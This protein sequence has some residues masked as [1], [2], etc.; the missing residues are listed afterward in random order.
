MDRQFIIDSGLRQGKDINTINKALKLEGFKPY[1]PNEILREQIIDSG[2]RQGKRPDI[3]NKALQYEGIKPDYNPLLEKWGDVPGNAVRDAKDIGR[4]LTSFGGELLTTGRDYVEDIFNQP[5]GKRSSKIAESFSN[6]I[7]SSALQKALL[8][9]G[10]GA[11]AGRRLGSLGMIPGAILGGIVST[12]GPKETA[13]ALL[14][15]YNTKIEDFNPTNWNV[16]PLAMIQGA[17]YKP[18]EASLD[19]LSLGGAKAA[20][21]AIKGRV[22]KTAIANQLLPD[23][24]T[25]QFNRYITN[26]INTSR[27]TQSKRYDA[28]NALLA[29]PLADREKIAN[30]LI[31]NDIAGL[32]EKELNIG[33]TIK[34][35]LKELENDIV[36]RGFMESDTVR[37]NVVSQYIM[38]KLGNKT[39][40]LLQKDVSDIINGR[41][42][43]PEIIGEVD[44]LTDKIKDLAKEGNKLYNEGKI[45]YVSQALKTSTDPRGLVKASEIVDPMGGYFD[46]Q[47]IIGRTTTKELAPWLDDTLNYQLNTLNKATEVEDVIRT[48]TNIDGMVADLPVGFT[49]IRK[50]GKDKTLISLGTLKQA[51]NNALKEGKLFDV[52]S[53]INTATKLT[54]DSKVIDK[55]KLEAIVNALTPVK[56]TEGRYL[57][58][59]FKKAALATPHWVAQ[60]RVGNVSNNLLSG[61]TPID[62]LDTSKYREYTPIELKQT[63]SFGNFVD[64]GPEGFKRSLGFRDVSKKGITKAI[65]SYKQLMG[66]EKNYNN[67]AKALAGI[68]SGVSEIASNPVFKFEADLE[69]T[70]RF[71]NY[72]RQAKR[73]AKEHNMKVEAVLEKAKTDK[74]LKYEFINQGNKD[75]GDYI[76]R[77]Y[78]M[79]AQYHRGLSDLVPFYRFLLQTG[80][81]S[82]HQLANYPLAFQAMIG[83]PQRLGNIIS[84]NAIKDY[85]L[86]KD[87]YTGGVPIYE[88]DDGTIRTLGAEPVPLGSVFSNPLAISPWLSMAGDI[89]NFRVGNRLA[90]S[91]ERTQWELENPTAN[92]YSYRPSLTEQGSLALNNFLNTTFAPYR[93][94][95]NQFPELFTGTMNSI[96]GLLGKEP[97]ASVKRTYDTNP[98]IEVPN[99][100]Q[101]KLPSETLGK[102]LGYAWRSNYQNPKHNP[103]KET[104]VRALK[105]NPKDKNKVKTKIR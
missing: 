61:V 58:N 4:D 22:S 20:G 56:S 67:I 99:S 11:V 69:L 92:K 77:N 1:N 25:A 26:A 10:A 14:S 16:S 88:M 60:N 72:I 104:R 45:V 91:P 51:I 90:T 76:G 62:Y 12:V 103:K 48:L 84:E 39:D 3:I 94:L 13:N 98:L 31:T 82:L 24:P 102:W 65:Q 100:Y 33:K 17:K 55:A 86:N 83:V 57:M 73:Y 75:L 79:P 81:V 89:G 43:R 9:V 49:D 27:A 5:I 23:A 46:T 52:K 2:I 54:K 18:V 87:Y 63:T 19:I 71:A 70:D 21:K 50:L 30:F 74:K 34:S 85:N 6:A 44:R 40:F 66:S 8:G 28:L 42:I 7:K 68:Y 80:R 53:V 59:A 64:I 93:L 95:R 101:R 96:A 36:A 37:N 29:S 41:P 47:R 105:L 78:M 38:N 32:T 97:V 15:P 35:E